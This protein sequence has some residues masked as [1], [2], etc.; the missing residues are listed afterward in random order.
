MSKRVPLRH[1][2]F[3]ERLAD[4]SEGSSAW[5]A[6]SA[7]LV[8]LRL[9][10]AWIEEG[11]EVVR[12]GWSARAARDA[13]DAMDPGVPSRAILGG[14]IDA[15]VEARVVDPHL[16]TPRLLAYGQA[17]A[18]DAS[19]DLAADVFESLVTHARPLE[20]HDLVVDAYIQ[21]GAARRTR[22]ELDAAEA[23]YACAGEV[24]EEADYDLGLL[25]VRLADARLA[26]DR[27]NLPAA[28]RLLDRTIADASDRGYRELAS[29]ARHQRSAVAFHRGDYARAIRDAYD[30][31]SGL[32]GAN[33]RDRALADLAAAFAELGCRSVARDA[34]LILAATAQEQH[35][36]WTA[37]INLMEIA[38]LDGRE[39]VFEQY[40]RELSAAPLPPML[41]AWAQLYS[42]TGLLGFGRIER[43]RRAIA[44]AVEIAERH[45]LNQVVFQAEEALAGVD[46]AS[47]AMPA[48]EE[49]P[50]AAVMDVV[51]QLRTMREMAGV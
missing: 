44:S 34:H 14:I 22:G 30:A 21:L 51:E 31:L 40:R 10:D 7:G 8:V 13:V 17:L 28:E 36:R 39:P 9:V 37:T 35:V 32:E 24:A 27:G 26:V 20:E 38:A 46:K 5:R 19:Y 3:F 1:L 48:R 15:M 23:A 25:R 45:G 29:L 2:P 6:I 42:G 33:A 49:A 12:G 16:V 47:A 18:L 11:P 4:A 41:Q 43:A 50:P